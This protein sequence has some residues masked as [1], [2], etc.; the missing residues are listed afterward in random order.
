MQVSAAVVAVVA[1]GVAVVVAA[2]AA[3][4][5]VAAEAVV[6]V[7]VVAVVAVAG[8]D[9]TLPSSTISPFSAI[10][11]MVSASIASATMAANA[12]MSA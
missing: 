5:A 10:S 6:A 9:R 11:Q 8:V 4:V 7:A 3:V 2:S 1:P 12:R